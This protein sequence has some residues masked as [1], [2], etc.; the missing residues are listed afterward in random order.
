MS[1]VV[2]TEVSPERYLVIYEFIHTLQNLSLCMSWN[3]DAYAS[4]ASKGERCL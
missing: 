1:K 3:I 2:E 4:L